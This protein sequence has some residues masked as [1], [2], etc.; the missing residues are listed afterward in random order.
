MS[1]IYILAKVVLFQYAHQRG[2]NGQHEN[3]NSPEDVRR[4]VESAKTHAQAGDEEDHKAKHPLKTRQ[5]D[6]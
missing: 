4:F 5:I 1:V 3:R 6:K 2:P